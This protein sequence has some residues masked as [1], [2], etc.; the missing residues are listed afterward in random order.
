MK[1][2]I[3]ILLKYPKQSRVFIGITLM[4]Q[5]LKLNK[6]HMNAWLSQALESPGVTTGRIYFISLDA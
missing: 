5:P 1:Y 6:M 4:D 2:K 3:G